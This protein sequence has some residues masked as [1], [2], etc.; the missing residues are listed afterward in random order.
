MN[1]SE[2]RMGRPNQGLDLCKRL[3]SFLMLLLAEGL[4]FVYVGGDMDEL[5][6]RDVDQPLAV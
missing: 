4:Q 2:W 6:G 5:L 1:K 3:S